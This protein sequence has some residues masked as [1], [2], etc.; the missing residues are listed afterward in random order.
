MVE[1]ERLLESPVS[2]GK[3][4]RLPLLA[5]SG[6]PDT[7]GVYF[8]LDQGE[9]VWY[10]GLAMS[11]RQRWR[12]HEHL[13]ACRGNGVENIAWSECSSDSTRKELE[14]K[15]IKFFQPPINDRMNHPELPTIAF[16]LSPDQEVERFIRLQIQKRLIDMELEMLKPNL[17]SHCQ[18]RP[19]GKITHALGTIT[20]QVYRSWLFSSEVDRLAQEL[21]D[22]KASE[23]VEC[24][25]TVKS[26]KL[27]PVT[28]VNPIALRGAT[29]IHFD[30]LLTDCESDESR[31]LEAA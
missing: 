22:Q 8:A 16:G 4:P 9:R 7:G 5:L 25:A 12:A 17:V 19:D 10:V 6:L 26:T 14:R 18:A 21:K 28:R 15:C 1:L 20:A 13:E 23:K 30:D 31:E 27:S 3:L 29:K 11:L 24:V 2:I